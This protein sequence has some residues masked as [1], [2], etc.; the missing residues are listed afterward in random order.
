MADPFVVPPR[1]ATK[2]PAEPPEL[3]FVEPSPAEIFGQLADHAPKS[4]RDRMGFRAVP[5]EQDFAIVR[6][7]NLAICA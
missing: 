2:R 4:H 7:E 1:G 3:E 5:V 6:G